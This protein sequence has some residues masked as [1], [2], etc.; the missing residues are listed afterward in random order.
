MATVAQQWSWRRSVG[1]VPAAALAVVAA[2]VIGPDDQVQVPTTDADFYGPG[3]Q[4]NPDGAVFANFYA[5]MDCSS[6]HGSYAPTTAPFRNW[7]GSM[8]AQ[9]ARD[10]IWQ[11]S[12]AIANQDVAGA[13]Q[14]CIRC[15]APVAWLGDRH[16]DGEFDQFEWI[17]DFD[18]VNCHF[19]HRVV[20][21]DIGPISAVGYADNFPYDPDPDPE[22]VTPLIL[23]GD[24]PQA[25]QRSNGAYVVDPGDVRR[26]P[27]D[28][29]PTNYHSVPMH[30]SP[31]HS[32]SAF[33][34]TCHDVSNI[35]TIQL[36]DGTYG[37]EAV[38]AA[39][40]TGQIN[41]MF[42]EQRTYSEWLN[43]QFAVSGV[44]YPDGRFGGNHPTGVMSTCQDCHMPDQAG[45]GCV[46]L[47]GTEYE[48]PDVPQHGFAGANSWVVRAVR[49]Q[50]GDD[51]SFLGL[52]QSRTDDGVAR[53]LQMLRD[54]SDTE[55]LQKGSLLRVRV[56][57][58]SGHKLPTGI[59]EGR[60]M[61]VYVRFVDASNAT[62][63]ESGAYNFAT[64]TL[65]DGDAKQYGAHMVTSGA[66]AAVANIPDGTNFHIA[67]LNEVVTD[68]RIPPRGFTNAA[69]AA[70]GGEPRGATYADGQYWDDTH[71]EI[72]AGANRAIV[73]VYHQT[74]TREYIE[75]LRDANTTNTLG[76]VAYD[77]W[78]QFGRSAP[79]AMDSVSLT[80]DPVCTTGDINCDGVVNGTDVALVLAYWGQP[81]GDTNGD[82]TTDGADL[83]AVLG[84]WG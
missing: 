9:S 79:V 34:G 59:A 20:N 35:N 26:G 58:Q 56:T 7:V 62:L 67:L 5:G 22:I 52:T 13:G 30:Y 54:A 8:M 45:A 39:H 25:T 14:S 53:N 12:V 19:C 32:Q 73:I 84:N 1:A 43:S 36:A 4:P 82:G 55:L 28:D 72:P 38:G 6:C 29:V 47:V 51:A 49:H 63:W 77:L 65:L 42:P 78:V 74:T 75:F 68:N 83:A 76:Q 71:Y 18:G 31:F 46:L 61:W 23:S 50:M 48:R 16:Q 17:T 69:Y 80:L 44:E 33:C 41:D 15:H 37:V 64:G 10:P 27:F 40:A 66:M 70:F 3:T 57:N 21:P 24:W 81:A 2:A 11:A 60:R